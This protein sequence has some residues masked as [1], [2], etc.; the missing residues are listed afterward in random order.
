MHSQNYRFHKLVV[1]CALSEGGLCLPKQI[2]HLNLIKTT[3]V[4]V[5]TSPTKMDNKHP[6][7]T[8]ENEQEMLKV[9]EWSTTEPWAILLAL[10]KCSKRHQM[11]CSFDADGKLP[12]P[13][14]QSLGTGARF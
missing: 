3:T 7:F 2:L 5:L 10:Q 13:R 14:S 4:K 9:F 6:I 1:V 11:Y 12:R 8:L